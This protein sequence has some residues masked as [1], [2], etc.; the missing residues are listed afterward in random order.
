MEI[1]PFKSVREEDS[2]LIGMDLYHLCQL[3]QLDFPVA[4]GVI[5]LPPQLKIRTILEHYQIPE[6]EVLEQRLMLL[7]SQIKQIPQPEELGK[8]L[9]KHKIDCAKLWQYLLNH[10]IGQI[11][12]QILRQGFSPDLTLAATAQPVFLTDKISASGICFFNSDL[13]IAMFE[14][15]TGNLME[16]QKQDLEELVKKADQ[17]LLLPQIYSWVIEKNK[18]RLIKV[19]PST[20]FFVPEEIEEF[21]P[22]SFTEEKIAAPKYKSAL[23][24][25]L[26]ADESFRMENEADGAIISSHLHSNQ[27][28]KIL[29]LVE[30]AE[31]LPGKW[32]IFKLFDDPEKE[33]RGVLQLI[34]RPNLLKS[35]AEVIKFAR[36]NKHLANVGV[37][38]PFVRSPEELV[39]MKLELSSFRHYQTG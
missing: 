21:I 37:G 12:D 34:H 27:D 24:V 26:Q 11:R 7:E 23:K 10:W 3:T 5:V 29:Q 28:N 6:G 39:R 14:V 8:I 17:K 19:T 38:I 31:S 1:L 25:F 4:D 22:P 16:N 9:A 20:H 33:V 18:I 32:V 36:H 2:P 15:E 13:K 30:T 35:D